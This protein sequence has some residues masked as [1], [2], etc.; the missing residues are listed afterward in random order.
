MT[1]LS[2]TISPNLGQTLKVIE[3]TRESILI[4][5]LATNGELKIRWEAMVKRIYYSLHLS[6]VMVNEREIVSILNVPG[7][8]NL[9]EKEKAIVRYKKAF[10]HIHS[11]WYMNNKPVMPQ[12]VQIILKKITDERLRLPENDLM[13]RLVF[14]QTS[15]EHTL[16]QSFI[17]YIQFYLLLPEN[18]TF[19]KLNRLLPYVFLYKAGLDYRGLLILEQYFYENE[20]LMRELRL[21]VERKESVTVWIE[22]FVNAIANHLED[23]LK[24]LSHESGMEAGKMWN[25]SERQ[26]EILT[27]F[28]MP[29]ARIT[30]KKVQQVFRI[31]QITSSR[32][33]AR[34]ASLGLLFQYGKGRSVYYMRA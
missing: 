12:A 15:R 20:R 7:K 6:H 5:P 16:V 26:K 33:L 32:D 18:E 14:L 21:A 11:F 27:T 17:A 22:H 23:A 2:Y 13:E 31:S 29:G 9:T 19:G 8:R 10:D 34:L 4:K 25:L 30:N 28:D 1:T 3:N 24:R